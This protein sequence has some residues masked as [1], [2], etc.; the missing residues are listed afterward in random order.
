MRNLKKHPKHWNGFLFPLDSD[1]RLGT[2]RVRN[3]THAKAYLQSESSGLDSKCN[4]LPL[5]CLSSTWASNWSGDFLAE[6]RLSLVTL[7]YTA[8]QPLFINPFIAQIGTNLLFSVL[9]LNSMPSRVR[10]LYIP[11]TNRSIPRI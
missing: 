3:V 2:N 6:T 5:A 1:S 11:I 8:R 7:L 4:T 9:M 10:V